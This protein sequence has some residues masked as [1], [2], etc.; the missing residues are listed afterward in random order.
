MWSKE[1]PVEHGHYWM[2]WPSGAKTVAS[3]YLENSGKHRIRMIS[4]GSYSDESDSKTYGWEYWS[5]KIKE[6][7]C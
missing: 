1:I 4:D 3:I 6:P 5:E 7:K 2:R